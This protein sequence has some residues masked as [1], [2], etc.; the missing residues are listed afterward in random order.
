MSKLTESRGKPVKFLKNVRS[1]MKKVIWPS[2]SDLV[3]YTGVVLFTCVIFGLGIWLV[4]SIFSGALKA[5]LDI[6]F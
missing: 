2:R 5:I 4:D 1:E 6:N 3:S